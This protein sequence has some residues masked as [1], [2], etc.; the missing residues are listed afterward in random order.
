[1]SETPIGKRK[2]VPSRQVWEHKTYDLSPWLQEDKAMDRLDKAL[3]PHLK[4]LTLA[5]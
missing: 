3:R 2:R 4:H 1:M 5:S